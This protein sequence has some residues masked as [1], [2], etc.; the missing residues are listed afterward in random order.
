VTSPTATEA[1][2]N[3]ASSL[4][5]R[6]VG[7]QSTS[8]ASSVWQTRLKPQLQLIAH[9]R[10]LGHGTGTMTLGA[11]Y[12]TPSVVF[13]GESDYG[14][15]A[16]EL[17]LPG[18]ALFVWFVGAALFFSLR[19]YRASTDWRKA[20]TMVGLGAA[21]LLSLWMLI[22]FAFDTPIVGEVFYLFIG[23]AIA[24]GTAVGSSARAAPAQVR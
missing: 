13:P 11:E 4:L 1:E 22:T 19:G 21:G 18:L 8:D 16:W 17:G 20:T 10:L 24:E 9:Q 3:G 7:I 14:K 6:A 2:G 12:S 5:S 23:L 15:L